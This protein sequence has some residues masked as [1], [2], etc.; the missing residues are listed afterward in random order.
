MPLT[1]M[2]VVS[3]LI[4][5][6]AM[7]HGSLCGFGSVTHTDSDGPN[8]SKF[9]DVFDLRCTPLRMSDNMLG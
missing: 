3:L 6:T 8:P 2:R 7:F 9:F 4:W 5:L 1:R